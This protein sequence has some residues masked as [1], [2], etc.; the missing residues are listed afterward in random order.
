MSPPPS[1][2]KIGLLGPYSFGNLGNAALQQA[3]AQQLLRIFPGSEIYG[4]C[5]DPL[6]NRGDGGVLPFPLSRNVR[7]DQPAP[8]SADSGIESSRTS[9]PPAKWK[10]WLKRIPLVPAGYR[11]AREILSK[12]KDFAD[13][14]AFLLRAYKFARHSRILIVGLGGVIDDLWNGPWGD[15]FL[16]FKWAVIAKIAGT[17][18]VF[19]SVGAERIDTR[20]GK[21]FLRRA[22]SLASYRSFRDEDSKRK[23][24][25]IGVTG[26]NWVFPDLAFG[27]DMPNRAGAAE[28]LGPS[29]LVG[30][31]P[32]AYCDPRV[33]PVENP[34]VY[35]KYLKTLS[36]F[37]LWLLREGYSVALVT[38]QIRMDRAPLRELKEMILKEASAEEAARLSEPEVQTVE[39]F[40]SFAS[41]LDFFVSS[42]LHGVVLSFLVGTPVLAF[43]HSEKIDWLMADLDLSQYCLNIE[44]DDAGELS[45]RVLAIE[46][47]QEILRE[48]IRR[49]VSEYR[50]SL[51]SQYDRVFRS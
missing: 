32:M 19:L 2:N 24:E 4:C 44:C 8:R 39:Q 14:C 22:L 12:C 45:K 18:L 26:K 1:R 15:P 9:P 13:E 21:F 50:A 6:T 25:A 16:L 30:V 31:S 7:V 11:L 48:R 33:W 46:S 5:I 27:L 28:A 3:L 35:E 41:Q 20:L 29:R 37:V 23:I 34:V 42:R 49:K 36:Q 10:I 38:T 40:L 47:N 17:P 43:S 51:Q